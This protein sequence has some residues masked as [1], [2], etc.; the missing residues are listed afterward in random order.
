[1]ADFDGVITGAPEWSDV[2]SLSAIAIALGGH[3]GSGV[4]NSQAQAI[5]K[6]L[7]FLLSYTFP[8]DVSSGNATL[9]ASNP[10]A[11]VHVNDQNATALL[12]TPDSPIASTLLGRVGFGSYAYTIGDAYKAA[13]EVRSTAPWTS[14]ST[15]IEFRFMA[16]PGLSS[17]PISK[18][19]SVDNLGNSIF[20]SGYTQDISDSKSDRRVTV[21]AGSAAQATEAN[22]FLQNTA[23]GTSPNDGLKVGLNGTDASVL[24]QE[25]GFLRLGT[26]KTNLMSM[27]SAGRVG[28]KTDSP[29]AVLDVN[30]DVKI[31]SDLGLSIGSTSVSS[32]KVDTTGFYLGLSTGVPFDVRYGSSAT[33]RVA[34]GKV[35]IN[36]PGN[37]LP[38]VSFEV[39]GTDAIKIAVGSTAQRSI[40]ALGHIRHNTDLDKPEFYSSLGWKPLV[41]AGVTGGGTN[42]VFFEN[43]NV[44]TDNYTIT[45]GKNAG[46]WGPLTI[47]DGVTVT[48]PDG[49]TWTIA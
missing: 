34:A 6:R 43:D 20:G 5:V 18:V 32:F 29:G 12:T 41:Q 48:I 1:M 31:S 33:L 2:P 17:D 7:N 24:N 16:N 25:A 26:N 3:A 38:T 42:Q 28:V 4:M 19:A 9:G 10:K 21:Y 37:S 30:G 35:G 8:I 22:V 15:P 45:A 49:S 11:K 44:I 47:A 46:S 23:S 27:T 40:G 36:T 14:T 39:N 13:L